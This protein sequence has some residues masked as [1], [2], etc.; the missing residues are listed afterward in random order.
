MKTFR[1]F[2]RIFAF[3]VVRKSEENPLQHS[4]SSENAAKFVE[5]GHF[6]IKTLL[7]YVSCFAL[8]SLFHLTV[9]LYLLKQKPFKIISNVAIHL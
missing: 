3:V 2:E 7:F 4:K 6:G 8:F 5:P 1:M 9:F